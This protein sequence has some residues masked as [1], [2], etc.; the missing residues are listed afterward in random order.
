MAYAEGN[1]LGKG[2]VLFQL[3]QESIQ[4]MRKL[5]AAGNSD[6][7]QLELRMYR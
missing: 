2:P 7:K 3:S 4:K 6:L 5:S 1:A